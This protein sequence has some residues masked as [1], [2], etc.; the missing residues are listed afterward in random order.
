[1]IFH[2]QQND[3][4]IISGCVKLHPLENMERRRHQENP[5]KKEI[6]VSLRKL[7]PQLNEMF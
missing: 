6:N 4:A 5:L 2:G 1:M 3:D 7:V